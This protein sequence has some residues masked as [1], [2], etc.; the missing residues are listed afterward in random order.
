MQRFAKR[1]KPIC[2]ET[3]IVALPYETIYNLEAEETRML[4]REAK[5]LEY[6][7][8]LNK[9][10]LKTVSAFA[11]YG[12]GVIVFGIDDDRKVIGIDRPEEKCLDIEN[13]INDSIR[14]KPSFSLKINEDTTICLT[15]AKGSDTP[16][17]YNGKCYKR[18]DSSTIEADA[19]EENRLVLE[20]MHL[21][22]EEVASK[23]QNLTFSLLGLE[24]TKALKLSE[25]NMDSLK[26]L[27]LYGEGGYN[28]AAALLAD[29]NSFGGLDIVVF[30]YTIN[31][32][33]K[34]IT[35]N[36]ISLL[37][38]YEEALKVFEDEYIIERIDG[39]FRKKYER[40]PYEA[41]REA[42]ANSLI[43]R[44]YDVKA[45]TKVEMYPDKIVVTSPGGLV[46]SITKEAFEKG[47]YSA[48]RN[49]IVA[50]VFHRLKIVE[51]FA[52]GIKR[53]N[54]SYA[55]S[56]KKPSFDVGDSFISVTLP[57]KE[58]IELSANEKNVLILMN[59][60]LDYTR[61]DLEKASRIGKAS[62]IRVLNSLIE[63]GLVVKKGAARSSFYQR[64]SN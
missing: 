45:N 62:L 38:Q 39:G 24:I 59:G 2:N 44:A 22:F 20:G 29:E 54:G 43:H 46:R 13:Q 57:V 51:A 35:L 8:N 64:K 41:Y 6:K 15:V 28:N 27:N 18:N 61:G 3:I 4:E 14:P 17:R 58:E 53:I 42:I 40:I 56:Q 31:E 26:S 52:T 30:G 33:K 10:Y 1:F 12:D 55:S 9:T 63:K 50:N 48:L 47:S 5:N 7:E 11:N 37:K 19:L 21:S 34:R 49:P 60:S 36:G 16:Y 23:E 25:F 32:F